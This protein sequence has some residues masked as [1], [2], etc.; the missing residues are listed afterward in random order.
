M[1]NQPISQH[2]QFSSQPMT[3]MPMQGP[4]IPMYAGVRMPEERKMQSVGPMP[5]LPP[6]A[7]AKTVPA[8]AT[9]SSVPIQLA[10]DFLNTVK[11][12][13]MGAI[14]NFIGNSWNERAVTLSL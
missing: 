1:H 2:Y 4:N 11:C 3:Q 14:Q 6:Q 10:K 12:G 7:L 13:D 5:N 8:Q 9:T